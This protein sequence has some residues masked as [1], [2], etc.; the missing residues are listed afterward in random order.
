MRSAIVQFVLPFL[1]LSP[2]QRPDLFLSHLGLEEGKGFVFE[3][4]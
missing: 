1:D 4:G 2:E 3:V